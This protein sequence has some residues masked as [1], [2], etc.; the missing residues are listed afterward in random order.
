MK[1]ATV[2]HILIDAVHEVFEKMYFIF[3][4]T[5]EKE[6]EGVPGEKVCISF[7]GPAVGTI[8]GSFPADLT[9]EM[10]G[11]ALNLRKEEITDEIRRDCLRECMNMVGGAFLQKLSPD[12]GF[13][14]SLPFFPGET[15]AR[16]E[17]NS[18]EHSILVAFAAE[19]S[20]GPEIEI[21][22]TMTDEK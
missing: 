3:L 8:S 2:R 11:N 7:S 13:H 20:A 15:S 6:E 10:I 9:D 12:K 21:R 16:V 17:R 5:K 1:Q 4:E 19:H 14:I 18:S 22:I